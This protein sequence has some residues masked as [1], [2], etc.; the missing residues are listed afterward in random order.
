[1]KDYPK[2]VEDFISTNF[3]QLG[4]TG[5][6][7]IINMAYEYFQERNKKEALN[8]MAQIKEVVD[9]TKVNKAMSEMN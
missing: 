1:M 9:K 3:M 4:T 5:L 8:Y 7:D 2:A 6:F